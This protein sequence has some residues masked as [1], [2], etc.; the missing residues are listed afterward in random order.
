MVLDTGAAKSFIQTTVSL[1]MAQDPRTKKAV[2][3]R[4]K[5]DNPMRV[6]G[7]EKGRNVGGRRRGMGNGWMIEWEEGKL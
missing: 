3:G 1:D 4:V 7:V 2:V 6:E 5:I